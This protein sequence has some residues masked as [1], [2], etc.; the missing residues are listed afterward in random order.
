[1]IPSADSFLGAIFQALGFTLLHFCWQGAVI[2]GL[3]AAAIRIPPKSRPGTRYLIGLSALLAM[4]GAAAVTFGYELTRH[5]HSDI[6]AGSVDVIAGGAAVAPPAGMVLSRWLPFVDALWLSGVALLSLRMAAGLWVIRR[7]SA[8]ARDVPDAIRRRFDAAL[9]RAGL[10]GRVRVRLNPKIDGP[11]VVGVARAVVYL[12]LSAVTALTP[13]QLD[14]VLAHELA[15]VRRGDYAWNLLQTVIETL[16]FFHPAVWWIGAALREQRELCCDD[17]ALAACH[18]PVTYATAL[19]SLEEQRRAPR[20]GNNLAMA[21][22][23]Q[24]SGRSLL[25]RITRILGDPPGRKAGR[26]TPLMPL[27]LPVALLTLAAVLLPMSPV[28]AGPQ[29]D[30]RAASA[31]ARSV[32]ASA[33]RP[34]PAQ[35]LAAADTDTPDAA[36]ETPAPEA[37]PADVAPDESTWNFVRDANT[38]HE[39]KATDTKALDRLA[40]EAQNRAVTEL[41]DHKAE[42]ER[43]VA[44]A[45]RAGNEAQ[46]Q[47]LSRIDLTAI[48]AAAQQI[49]EQARAEANVSEAERREIQAKARQVAAEAR[50]EFKFEWSRPPAYPTPPAPPEAPAAPASPA[51]APH[52]APAPEPAPAPHPVALAVPDAD[53]VQVKMVRAAA[54]KLAKPC[55]DNVK[56]SMTANG[57]RIRVVSQDGKLVIVDLKGPAIEVD[58]RTDVHTETE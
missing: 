22:N 54:A 11:F 55:K 56:V 2:A 28:A 21:L 50:N 39:E 6:P 37:T 32:P 49:A 18:D 13:D 47:A 33:P 38:T 57:N 23:G 30:A 12:P 40:T 34:I 1:M 25:S 58:N 10:T 3:Y 52:P 29:A 44:E 26:S 4:A 20:F 8:E 15:H 35:T 36:D 43:A 31:P 7:L 27:A 24:G 48:Q 53:H 9:E 17:V 16:F 14:A 42:I 45:R 46:A 5:A 19:L 51:P 41:S